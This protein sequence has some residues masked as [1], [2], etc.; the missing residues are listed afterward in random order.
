MMDE[1]GGSW[2]ATSKKPFNRMKIVD[3][4]VVAKWSF[5]YTNVSAKLLSRSRYCPVTDK[6][7]SCEDV[8]GKLPTSGGPPL[9]YASLRSPNRP[10]Q[11]KSSLGRRVRACRSPHVLRRLPRSS[12]VDA[13][14]L[15][16]GSPGRQARLG[17]GRV[18]LFRVA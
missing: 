5:S 11:R 15:C 2:I 7:V 14:D 18:L 12:M 3:M 1:A 10:T 17:E 4:V 6:V 16:S 9:L 8:E 13:A